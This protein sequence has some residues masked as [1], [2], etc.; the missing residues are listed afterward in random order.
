M[1]QTAVWVKLISDNKV[2]RQDM[3][4]CEYKNAAEALNTLCERMDISRPLW[5]AKNNREWHV[6]FRTRFNPDQFLDTVTFDRMEMEWI[7][8]SMPKKRN[9]D[10]RNA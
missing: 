10:P 8:P 9:G 5:L 6:F 4:P 7:N 1:N 2:I 3:E